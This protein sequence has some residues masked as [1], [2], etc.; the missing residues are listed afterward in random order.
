MKSKISP[1]T[2]LY[3]K[4]FNAP[5]SGEFE[6]VIPNN[7]YNTGY[8]SSFSSMNDSGLRNRANRTAPSFH[9]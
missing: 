9:V 3:N 6:S 2:D 1:S 4:V 5:K 8:G 7:G